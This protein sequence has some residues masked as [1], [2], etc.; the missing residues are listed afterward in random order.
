VAANEYIKKYI[1]ISKE[2]SVSEAEIAAG[3]TRIFT[4]FDLLDMSEKYHRQ[5]LRLDPENP[6]R[7]NSLAYFL[8][9]NDRNINEGITLVDSALNSRPDNYNYLHTKG[10]AFYKQGKYQEALETLQKS[11]DLRREKAVYNHQAYVHLEAA[12]KAVAG[13]N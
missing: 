7:L 1:S 3:L 4:G 8:I 11:W 6:D 13:M 12:K 10:W 5:A 2:R 9:D